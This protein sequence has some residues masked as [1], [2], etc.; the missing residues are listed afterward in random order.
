MKKSP[1]FLSAVV[2]SLVAA[3]I[4]GLVQHARRSGEDVADVQT[5]EGWLGDQHHPEADS[6]LIDL[7]LTSEGERVHLSLKLGHE[8]ADEFAKLGTFGPRT[9]LFAL[10]AFPKEPLLMDLYLVVEQG[11]D[12][13]F[14]I[15]SPGTGVLR[16]TFHNVGCAQTGTG[17]FA[18][19]LTA[20]R[21][22]DT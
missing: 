5:F 15:E 4:V 9:Y 14:G 1:S 21:P 3:A 7:V 22:E 20:L 11:D 16:G 17:W 10:S 18:C 12:F 2:A 19:E 6:E 8:I 13:F